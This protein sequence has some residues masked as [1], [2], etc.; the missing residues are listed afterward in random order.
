MALT[1]GF[2]GTSL[3]RRFRAIHGMGAALVGAVLLLTVLLLLVG[4]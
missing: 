3:P 1:G 4:L 2:P